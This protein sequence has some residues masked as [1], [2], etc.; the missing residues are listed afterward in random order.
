MKVAKKYEFWGIKIIKKINL[1]LT[2]FHYPIVN[3][4][5]RIDFNHV[6]VV[7]LIA[8]ETKWKNDGI[9]KLNFIEFQLHSVKK[10]FISI[11]LYIKP[12][13]IPPSLFWSTTASLNSIHLNSWSIG[14]HKNVSWPQKDE[15]CYIETIIGYWVEK[16]NSMVA[17]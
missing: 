14:T 8:S 7:W 16:W 6:T 1:L 5:A 10:A 17:V 9:A 4:F 12:S 11:C 13:K 15:A 3:K 2:F